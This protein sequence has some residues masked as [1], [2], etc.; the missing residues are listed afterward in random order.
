MLTLTVLA[1]SLTACATPLP[2]SPTPPKVPPA[3]PELMQP[4]D[5]SEWSESVRR[6]LQR[7]QQVLIAPPSS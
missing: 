1:L 5:S 2:V 3:P 6:L 4:P 7:W